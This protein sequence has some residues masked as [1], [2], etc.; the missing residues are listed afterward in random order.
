MIAVSF[1]YAGIMKNEGLETVV[2]DGMSECVYERNVTLHSSNE[3]GQRASRRRFREKKTT[4]D[5]RDLEAIYLYL[6]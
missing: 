5:G 3:C 2:N 6:G 1:E 4:M